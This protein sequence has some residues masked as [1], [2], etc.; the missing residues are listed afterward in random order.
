MQL[1][2]RSFLLLLRDLVLILP[3]RWNQMTRRLL[4]ILGILRSRFLS[5]NPERR[6][7]VLA[8]AQ[9]GPAKSNLTTLIYASQLPPPL[10]A[11][12]GDNTSLVTSLTPAAISIAVRGL[13]VDDALHEPHENHDDDHSDANSYMLAGTNPISRSPDIAR[14]HDEPDPI[15]GDL[16]Q[17]REESTSDSPAT[18]SPSN[19][20]PHSPHSHC[21]APLPIER[22]LGYRPE[23]QYSLRP[24]P[25]SSGRLPPHLSDAEAA[26]RGYFP[27]PSFP[28]LPSSA[29]S[30]RPTSVASSASSRVTRPVTPVRTASITDT[31]RRGNR[32]STPASAHQRVHETPLDSPELREVVPQ[33]T[34]ST[35]GGHRSATAGLRPSTP[36]QEGRLR[37]MIAINRY[38]KHREVRVK[39]SDEN[40]VLPPVTTE[41]VG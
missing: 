4:Y 18:I 9:C 29:Q 20:R 6:D 19:P 13:P 30:T 35:H 25:E 1:T 39:F 3:S 14:H 23:S 41:F 15:N 40:H 32:S 36:L 21:P 37:P 26:A 16:S 22:H 12:T 5:R 33:I 24:P 11:I 2:L 27:A 31:P 10:T 28:V 7:E 8:S 17:N 34:G 38:K